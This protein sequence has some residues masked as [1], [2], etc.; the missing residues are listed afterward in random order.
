MQLFIDAALRQSN[1]TNPQTTSTGS[2]YKA[3]MTRKHLLLSIF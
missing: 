3:A 1:E 2:I